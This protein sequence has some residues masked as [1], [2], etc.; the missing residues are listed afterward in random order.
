MG[1]DQLQPQVRE[2]FDV[3]ALHGT[4]RVMYRNVENW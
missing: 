3:P 1:I 4:R 2:I